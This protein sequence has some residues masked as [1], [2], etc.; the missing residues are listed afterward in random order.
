LY[1]LIS[2]TM[3]QKM[4][5]NTSLKTNNR[6]KRDESSEQSGKSTF[7]EKDNNFRR[8]GGYRGGDRGGYRGGSRDRGGYRG[9]YRGG[10]R[11]RG[12]YRGGY[13][14]RSGGGFRGRG[15]DGPRKPAN[16]VLP[17]GESLETDFPILGKPKVKN[18]NDLNWRV[19]AKKG[20]E[21]PPPPLFVKKMPNQ[22]DLLDEDINLDD[23]D[24][25]EYDSAFCDEDDNIF[26]TK[27]G[28][29]D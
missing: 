28:Y 23:Y 7:S 5:N 27:G 14:G 10:S 3:D 15:R 13:R 18:A 20:A 4:T 26:P 16:F 25:E 9:G 19:A 11:D 22:L 24:E 8:N 29:M 2:I 17:E 1:Q 6:W 21:A 12:G